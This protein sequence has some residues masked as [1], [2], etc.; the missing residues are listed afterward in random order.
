MT[1]PSIVTLPCDCIPDT[2]PDGDVLHRLWCTALCSAEIRVRP[3]PT[4]APFGGP[5][6]G[7]TIEGTDE[8]VG[9]A[10]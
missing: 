7:F 6:Q 5:L 2:A 9:G 4:G 1:T 10:A 8:P 3:P